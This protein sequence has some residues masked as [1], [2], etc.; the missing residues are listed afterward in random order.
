MLARH[1]HVFAGVAAFDNHESGTAKKARQGI[2]RPPS[3]LAG[4]VRESWWDANFRTPEDDAMGFGQGAVIGRFMLTQDMENLVRR[5]PRAVKT[6][7]NAQATGMRPGV[8]NG[9]KG[10]IVEGIA[11]DPE[12]TSV[13][14]VTKAGAGGQVASLYREMVAA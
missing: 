11:H 14:L 4:E 5:L 2:P 3:E 8:R 6:S 13:D 9:R 12:N 7:V 10:M 1:A